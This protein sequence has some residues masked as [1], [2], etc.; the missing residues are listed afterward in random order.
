MAPPGQSTA[1][2]TCIKVLLTV[3]NVVIL[4]SGL[5]VLAVGYLMTRGLALR[6]HV[7][8]ELTSDC[9]RYTA[10]YILIAVGCLILIVALLGCLCTFKGF[11]ALLYIFSVFLMLIFI[12]ELAT[13]ISAFIYYAKLSDGVKASLADVI[14]NYATA[15]QNKKDAVDYIQIALKC[16]G[17]DSYRDWYDVDWS[18]NGTVQAV[19]RSCCNTMQAF[20][21]CDVSST[22]DIYTDGCLTKLL[23]FM[24]SKFLMIGGI[25]IGYSF[26]QL[27]GVLLTCCL[28]KYISRAKY[29]EVAG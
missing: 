27:F 21:Q 4:V 2:V 25:A 17:N 26:L 24:E 28:A 15:K 13:A 10:V 20:Y 6:L 29:D 9:C 23:S 11:P 22:D 8:T 18:G 1:A 5:A 12:V 19:P 14:N 16:C 3:F 7:Y